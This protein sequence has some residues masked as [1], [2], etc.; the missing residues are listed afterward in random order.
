MSKYLEA[1]EGERRES[2]GRESERGGIE[3]VSEIERIQ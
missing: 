1:E 3:R 2:S